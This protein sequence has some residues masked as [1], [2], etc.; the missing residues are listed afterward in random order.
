[1]QKK[2][3]TQNLSPEKQ[4]K[5]KKRLNSKARIS[6]KINSIYVKQVGHGGPESLT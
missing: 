4:E 2:L 1:M 6:A 5:S 3:I